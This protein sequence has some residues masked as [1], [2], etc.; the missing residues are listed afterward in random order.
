M[1][2][3]VCAWLGITTG[4][5]T[6][7]TTPSVAVVVGITVGVVVAGRWIEGKLQATA[8]SSHAARRKLTR[9]RRGFT[10]GCLC[11]RHSPS[12]FP[13]ACMAGVLWGT[14]LLRRLSGQACDKPALLSAL[15]FGSCSVRR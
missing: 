5:P 8:V 7:I 2:G 14:T 11:L 9:R 6:S 12:I 1:A 13:S 15:V 10:L 3:E 4:V